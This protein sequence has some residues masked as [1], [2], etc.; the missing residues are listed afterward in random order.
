MDISVLG[1]LGVS[2]SKFSS[3]LG[4]KRKKNKTNL[5]TLHRSLVSS[6]MG[7]GVC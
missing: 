3:L 4:S 5:P 7:S 2:H 6:G 1:S